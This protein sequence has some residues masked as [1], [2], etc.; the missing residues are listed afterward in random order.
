MF[1]YIKT[2]EVK[3]C[4]AYQNFDNALYPHG[5]VFLDEPETHLHLEMQYEVLPLLTN[6]FPN[7][8]FIV[9]THSPAI[10]SSLKDA[11][12]YDLSSQNSTDSNVPK[13]LLD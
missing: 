9:A 1:P 7:I 8:Q 13:A 2:I 10:I 5:I 4:Y 3:D 12:V 6:L 11:T